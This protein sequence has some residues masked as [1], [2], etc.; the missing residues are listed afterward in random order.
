MGL[1]ITQIQSKHKEQKEELGH[2]AYNCGCGKE[3]EDE[4][5]GRVREVA[6]TPPQTQRRFFSPKSLKSPFNKR[7]T[8]AHHRGL[9]GECEGDGWE[10][11]W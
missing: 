10:D 6:A 5:D 8:G 1:L 4:V 3:E 11:C 9:S 2:C 7:V